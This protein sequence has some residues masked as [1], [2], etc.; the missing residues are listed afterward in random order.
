[1]SHRRSETRH[2][3]E[4]ITVRCTADEKAEMAAFAAAHGIDSLSALLML[5]YTALTVMDTWEVARRG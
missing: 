1:M 4:T 3:T 2:K 5:G